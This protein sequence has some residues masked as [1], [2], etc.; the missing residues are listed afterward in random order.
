[1]ANLLCTDSSRSSVLELIWIRHGQSKKQKSK[2]MVTTTALYTIVST[3]E[4]FFL[5][6]LLRLQAIHRTMYFPVEPLTLITEE[7]V[8]HVTVINNAIITIT[9]LP[10]CVL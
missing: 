5:K 3:L 1:M 2:V 9:D 7:A 8:Y 4:V 6:H 10:C